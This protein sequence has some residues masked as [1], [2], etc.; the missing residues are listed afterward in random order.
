MPYKKSTK[1]FLTSGSVSLKTIRTLTS[2]R[3]ST[4]ELT[5][6]MLF[7]GPRYSSKRAHLDISSEEDNG[8]A[9]QLQHDALD[10]VAKAI[11]NVRTV[12]YV[13]RFPS[14]PVSQSGPFRP[15]DSDTRE[16]DA[17]LDGSDESVHQLFICSQD[18]C[19][20]AL[21]RV[22][23]ARMMSSILFASVAVPNA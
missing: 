16:F 2:I 9:Q 8:F 10:H 22:F 13:I 20:S 19:A 4:R 5:E 21:I 14:E 7:T 3:R 6:Q 15:I 12:I 17:G 1:P 18:E 11:Q 23:F